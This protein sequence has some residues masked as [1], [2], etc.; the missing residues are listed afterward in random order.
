MKHE[1]KIAMDS[2]WVALPWIRGCFI[3]SLGWGWMSLMG[4]MDSSS[5]Q[6]AAGRGSWK[7]TRSLAFH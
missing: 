2:L 5:S 7:G 3:G 1:R 6:H 4:V